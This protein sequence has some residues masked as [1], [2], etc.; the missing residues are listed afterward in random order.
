MSSDAFLPSLYQQTPKHQVYKSF[1]TSQILQ[2]KK[3]IPD[4]ETHPNLRHPSPRPHHPDVMTS[5]YFPVLQTIPVKNRPLL[6]SITVTSNK[7][8]CS[9]KHTRRSITTPLSR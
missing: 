8:K 1:V 3:L 2:L 9:A 6:L 5:R 7:A 4:S